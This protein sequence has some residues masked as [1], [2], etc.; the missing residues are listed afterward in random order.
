MEIHFGCPRWRPSQIMFQC[1]AT[2]WYLC[3]NMKVMFIMT[4][5]MLQCTLHFLFYTVIFFIN[6]EWCILSSIHNIQ[7]QCQ[8]NT[9]LFCTMRPDLIPESILRKHTTKCNNF[10]THYKN[11]NVIQNVS[12]TTQDKNCTTLHLTNFTTSYKVY[13]YTTYHKALQFYNIIE[14]FTTTTKQKTT[15]L[16]SAKLYTYYNFTYNFTT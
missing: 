9:A 12:V 2:E 3:S 15:T 13:N 11:C 14:N 5:K 8:T 4:W 1:W 10:T 16:Q 7:H 6:C